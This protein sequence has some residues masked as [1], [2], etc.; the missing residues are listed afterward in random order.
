MQ[1][2]QNQNKVP[3]EH[4]HQSCL[5]PRTS[6]GRIIHNPKLNPSETLKLLEILQLSKFCK[7]PQDQR[8]LKCIT[9]GSLICIGSDRTKQGGTALGPF[10][11]EHQPQVGRE[12]SKVKLAC[13]TATNQTGSAP[14][15]LDLEQ[16]LKSLLPGIRVGRVRRT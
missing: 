1:L 2:L 15:P 4:L 11:G 5:K 9:A 14:G 10:N 12:G 3:L 7:F 8:L 16:N 6:T 13:R